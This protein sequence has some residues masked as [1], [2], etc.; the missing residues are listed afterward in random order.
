[1]PTLDKITSKDF[2]GFLNQTIQVRAGNYEAGWCLTEIKPLAA[3]TAALPDGRQGFSLHF[4][5]PPQ[6]ALPQGIYA[7]EHPEFGPL[8]IFLVPIAADR[9][10]YYLEAIFN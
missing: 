2:E 6:P 10:G 9:E 1:M 8:E 7:V 5:A 4:K 3:T